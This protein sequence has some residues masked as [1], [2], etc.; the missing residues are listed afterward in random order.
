[1]P[2]AV[3]KALGLWPPA[4]ARL[5]STDIDGGEVEM[6]YIEAGAELE[7]ECRW[8]VVNVVVNPYIDE[9]LL[10][11]YVAG[12][13]C[14][15]VLDARRGLWRFCNE[16]TVKQSAEPQSGVNKLQS[17]GGRG[18]QLDS[19][20]IPLFLLVRQCR[21]KEV[22]HEG[23]GASRVLTGVSHRRSRA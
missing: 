19:Q 7:L 4:R 12:E 14:I 20:P 11:D 21:G 1:M 13:L 3:A 16:D 18:R 23:R 9:V 2:T 22:P 15:I 5:V 10:S 6:A 8:L 17:L